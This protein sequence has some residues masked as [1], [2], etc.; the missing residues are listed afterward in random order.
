MEMYNEINVVFFP[1]NNIHSAA[2]GS[3]SICDFQILYLKNT[4]VTV[5]AQKDSSDESGENQWKIFWKGFTIIHSIMN[6]RDSQEEAKI[7]ALTGV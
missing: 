5:A 1:A 3:R 6:T 2:S 7:P 4:E